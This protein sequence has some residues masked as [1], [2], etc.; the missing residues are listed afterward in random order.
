MSEKQYNTYENIVPFTPNV[1]S[2]LDF[3]T[4]YREN[5]LH[6]IAYIQGNSLYY[7]K[8]YNENLPATESTS[9]LFSKNGKYMGSIT[10]KVGG[11]VKLNILDGFSESD[12][13]SQPIP[14][15]ISKSLITKE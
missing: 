3:K 2:S 7:M 12:W 6:N 8:F 11:E 4:V 10:F 15:F 13:N 1:G 5:T 14:Y 9:P